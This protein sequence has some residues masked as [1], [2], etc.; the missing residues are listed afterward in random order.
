MQI[1]SIWTASIWAAPVFLARMASAAL[2]DFSQTETGRQS[3]FLMP[4]AAA[5]DA[6]SMASASYFSDGARER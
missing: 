6:V 3:A 5:A 2:N 4:P 1:A